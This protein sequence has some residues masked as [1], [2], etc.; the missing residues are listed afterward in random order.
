MK[1]KQNKKQTN[2]KG[3]EGREK[4][5]ST[6][7]AYIDMKAFYTHRNN[8]KYYKIMHMLISTWQSEKHKYCHDNQKGTK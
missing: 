5:Q 7:N 2:K 4:K 1:Q 8:H 6:V 3:G